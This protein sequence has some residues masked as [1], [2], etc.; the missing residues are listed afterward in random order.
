M[1]CEIC[2][3]QPATIWV[4]THL[5]EA[6]VSIHDTGQ[7]LVSCSDCGPQLGYEILAPIKP[8]EGPWNP[9]DPC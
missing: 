5:P 8:V 9:F 2:D 6:K 3:E 7:P 4:Q 1:R